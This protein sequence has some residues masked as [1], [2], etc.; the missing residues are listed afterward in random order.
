MPRFISKPLLWAFVAWHATR[1]EQESL[2]TC[3]RLKASFS[4]G[5]KV[6]GFNSKVITFRCRAGWCCSFIPSSLVEKPHLLW[7]VCSV[8]SLFLQDNR[9]SVLGSDCVRLPFV[10]LLYLLSSWVDWHEIVA[11]SPVMKP[12]E[13]QFVIILGFLLFLGQMWQLRIETTHLSTTVSHN[14]SYHDWFTERLEMSNKWGHGNWGYSFQII[15][16]IF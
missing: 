4:W 9:C 7:R 14:N 10:L 15:E 6:T 8:P 2:C 11:W 1:S 13:W 16:V 12:H 5:Q 3:A